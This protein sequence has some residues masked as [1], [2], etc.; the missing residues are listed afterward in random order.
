MAT[1]KQTAKT[2]TGAAA[3]G[4]GPGRPKGVGN[5]TTTALKDA[6]LMAAEKEGEDGKGKG[7][8][9][10]YLRHVARTD[11]KAFAG[12]LGKVLPLQ[13]AGPNGGPIPIA[14][15]DLTPEQRTQ[16]V[17]RALAEF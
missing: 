1:K 12:L 10:G 16:L 7:K 8:L 17:E 11:T 4:R 3:R 15:V 9:T 5:R 6:I 13:I 2:L 14:S